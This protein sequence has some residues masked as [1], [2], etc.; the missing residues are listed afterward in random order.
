MTIE[1]AEPDRGATE[2]GHREVRGDRLSPWAEQLQRVEG[3]LRPG[4]IWTK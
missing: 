1:V 2:A 3:I 4:R